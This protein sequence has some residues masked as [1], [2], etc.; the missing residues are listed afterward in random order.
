MASFTYQPASYW[1]GRSGRLDFFL[2]ALGLNI[3]PLVAAGLLGTGAVGWAAMI[4]WVLAYRR[5]FHD[6]G[7][8]GKWGLVPI[9]LNMTPSLVVF[10]PGGA[11]L[12]RLIMDGDIKG[13][14]A[15]SPLFLM[16]AIG[17]NLISLLINILLCLWPGQAGANAYGP[18]R[19]KTSKTSV[20]T[21]PAA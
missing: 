5:R 18:A 15:E 19:K 13:A 20:A 21:A 8:S 9:L 6:L 4:G 11:H 16:L 12:G 10:L 14:L 7:L 1:S 17:A 3:V 2:W